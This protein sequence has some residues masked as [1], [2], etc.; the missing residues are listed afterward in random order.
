MINA[1]KKGKRFEREIAKY[2]SN[3]FNVNCRRTPQSGGMNFKGDVINL[4]GILARFLFE[5]KNQEKLNIWKALHQAI[6]DTVSKI[7]TVIFTKNFE[8]NYIALKLDDFV[9]L[10]LEIEELKTN[11]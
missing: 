9:N 8:D 11:D 1:N 4:S 2:L 5:C 7:P 10:L 6:N 3:K